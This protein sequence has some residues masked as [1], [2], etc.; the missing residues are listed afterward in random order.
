MIKSKKPTLIQLLERLP[1]HDRQSLM[2]TLLQYPEMASMVTHSFK[3]KRDKAD[4]AKI[5][6]FEAAC[7]EKISQLY[8]A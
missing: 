2:D 5:K 3:L 1:L 6:Q 8:G 4:P 7:L